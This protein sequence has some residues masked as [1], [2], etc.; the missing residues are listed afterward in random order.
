MVTPPAPQPAKRPGLLRRAWSATRAKVDSKVLVTSVLTAVVVALLLE[1][2]P[3]AVGAIRESLKDPPEIRLGSLTDTL[4]PDWRVTDR[5]D[6]DLDD[7]GVNEVIATAVTSAGSVTDPPRPRTVVVAWDEETERW[8]DVFDSDKYR[9]TRD[10]FRTGT[11]ES[12]PLFPSGTELSEALTVLT[13]RTPKGRDLVLGANL[14]I[15]NADLFVLARVRYENEIASVIYEATE[16]GS[17]KVELVTVDGNR[18]MRVTTDWNPLDQKCCPIGTATVDLAETDGYFATV[19]DLRPYLGVVFVLDERP[20]LFVASVHENSPAAGLLR[21]GDEVRGVFPHTPSADAVGPGELLA[22][23]AET[24]EGTS[25]T[26]AVLRDEEVISVD[27]Q[28]ATREDRPLTDFAT[29][30]TLHLGMEIAA[31]EP[32][33]FVKGLV[34]GSAAAA[35]GIP[36]GAAIIR[37]GDRDVEYPTDLWL[38]LHELSRESARV[39]PMTY[40]TEDGTRRAVEVTVGYDPAD[41]WPPPFLVL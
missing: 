8:N 35:A 1:G 32:G 3:W 15:G 24:P 26:L 34:E 13:D 29:P 39:V 9:V 38:E 2:G 31:G 37:V 40:E 22:H 7:D 41:E 21:P 16:R 6:V 4:G 10:L 20:T 14:R 33:A 12:E 18:R 23:L 11:Y 30:Q 17:G 19:E 5:R 27:I 28:M 36:E 25:M